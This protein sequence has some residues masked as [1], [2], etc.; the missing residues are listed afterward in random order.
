TGYRRKSEQVRTNA[1][2]DR[3]CC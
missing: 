1:R 3:E 2:F